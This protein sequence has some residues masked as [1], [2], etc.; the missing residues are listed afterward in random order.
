[1]QQILLQVAGFE[2]S[3]QNYDLVTKKRDDVWAQ[4]FLYEKTGISDKDKPKIIG[5]NI[6]SSQRH[7]AKRWPVKNFFAL[8]QE[9]QINN[10]DWK[11]AILAG[12]EER[13]LYRQLEKIQNEKPLKNIILTGYKNSISQFISLVNKIPIIVSADTFGMHVA[14]G[15]GK[16]VVSL[17][18]PQPYQE[19]YLYNKGT[20]VHLNLECAPCFASKIDGCVNSQR[21]QC[22]RSIDVKTVKAALKNEMRDFG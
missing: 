8:A 7:D 10:P 18:G 22:V 16:N 15:L 1:M 20:K 4:Q 21:L 11:L 6:G 14:I 17:S 5:L 9:F 3:E 12:S 2:W 13:D 19:V